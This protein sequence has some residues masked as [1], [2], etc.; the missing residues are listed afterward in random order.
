M[1]LGRQECCNLD[2]AHLNQ[3]ANDFRTQ[4]FSQCEQLR[5]ALS[6]AVER[7]RSFEYRHAVSIQVSHKRAVAR[8]KVDAAKIARVNRVLRIGLSS[9][10]VAD[11]EDAPLLTYLNSDRYGAISVIA[12]HEAR[13]APSEQKVS[14]NAQQR[15]TVSLDYLD[16]QRML[17]FIAQF[18]LDS[19]SRSH[20]SS[21]I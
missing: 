11:G 7:A 1:N 4:Q 21:M 3:P 6:A 5:E 8:S 10:L 2:G 17:N 16:E 9:K 20:V 14:T 19:H 12:R 15:E 13:I 18:R